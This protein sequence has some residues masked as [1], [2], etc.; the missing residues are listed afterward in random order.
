MLQPLIIKIQ[1]LRELFQKTRIIDLKDFSNKCI[2]EAALKNDRILA[3]IS[4]I[5]YSLYKLLSKV[6]IKDDKNWNKLKSNILDSIDNC[7]RLLYQKNVQAFEKSL[8]KVV[9][10]IS[11]VDKNLGH[12]VQSLL[13][14]ARVKQASRAYAFGLSLSQAAELTKAD[15]KNLQQYIG[16]TI[17][18]DDFGITLGINTRL[19]NL[20]E[21]I[22]E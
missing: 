10:N 11:S 13:D 22:N 3:E 14:K 15:K 18:H 2:E 5:S 17:I 4:L 19:T 21:L 7:T 9:F 1:K 20:K 12:F 16:Q 8:N 6:H